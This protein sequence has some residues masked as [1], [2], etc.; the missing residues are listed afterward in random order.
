MERILKTDLLYDFVHTETPDPK[1]YYS[2]MH[3]GWEMLYFMRGDADYV[4]G[5]SR[6]HLHRRDLLLI[7]PAT[8]HRLDLL[9]CAPYER[10]VLRFPKEAVPPSL[11][12]SIMALGDIYRISKHSHID[13]VMESLRLAREQFSEEDFHHFVRDSLGGIIAHLKYMPASQTERPSYTDPRLEAMLTYIDEH[14][15]NRLT[16]GEVAEKFFVSPSWVMHAFRRHLGMTFHKYVG[17]KKA[18]YAKDLI[19]SGMA[20]TRVAEACGFENYSTFYRQYKQHL[21]ASPLEDKRI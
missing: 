4:V 9:S 13:A 16:V 7:K 17:Q 20:P 2:H 10:T 19:E 15:Q 21:G 14:P 18:L 12:D 3:G 6:Y 11:R 5:S 8:F 1:Q